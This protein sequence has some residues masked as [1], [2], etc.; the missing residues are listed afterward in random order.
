MDA[1]QDLARLNPTVR[2]SQSEYGVFL[3]EHLRGLRGQSTLLSQ[4]SFQ[5]LHTPIDHYALGWSIIRSAE[6]G[7]LSVHDSTEDGYTH[8]TLLMPSQNRAVAILCNGK[9]ARSDAK[10]VKFA[11]SLL[12]SS[13]IK[14]A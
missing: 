5:Q 6:F 8:Y 9:S 7:P 1:L 14:I 10:L 3:R 4:T 11:E 2:L 13:M 12:T